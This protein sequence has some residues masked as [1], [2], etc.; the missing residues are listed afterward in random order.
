MADS[1]CKPARVIIVIITFGRPSICI[2]IIS[3]LI[4]LQ[5]VRVVWVGAAGG[6]LG[7]LPA[8]GPAPA[9]VG[10]SVAPGQPASQPTGVT[11][12]KQ[13]PDCCIP[14]Q[15]TL[16]GHASRSPRPPTINICQWPEPAR[17]GPA[18][19]I[20]SRSDRNP[21][22]HLLACQRALGGRLEPLKSLPPAAPLI[23]SA[24][25]WLSGRGPACCC[26]RQR[27][28]GCC[29]RRRRCCCLRNRLIGSDRLATPPAR[30]APESADQWPLI[31]DLPG[32][33]LITRLR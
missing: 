13:S 20:S 32:A 17:P 3:S 19:L 31:S 21:V 30:A 22:Y 2:S 4:E 28:S 14:L 9:Q 24:A 25:N 15:P 29:C 6:T 27:R 10:R 11:A 23:L 7:K 8:P 16:E 1:L 26:Q 18:R 33:Q 12:R 5:R